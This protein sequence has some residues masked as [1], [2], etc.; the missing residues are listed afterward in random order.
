[1]KIVLLRY[2]YPLSIWYDEYR[3]PRRMLPWRINDYFKKKSLPHKLIEAL[4][5]GSYDDFQKSGCELNLFMSVSTEPKI[6]Y[7]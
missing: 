5:L 4:K 2:C 3:R 7:L 6:Q 1:M